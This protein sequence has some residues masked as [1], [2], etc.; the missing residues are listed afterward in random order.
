MAKKVAII[1][2]SQG[3][4]ISHF[5]ENAKTIS[6]RLYRSRAKIVRTWVALPNHYD[7]QVADFTEYYTGFSELGGGS[8]SFDG[9]G[10]YDTIIFISHAGVDDGP[11][12]TFGAR[13]FQPWRR[14]RNDG[15]DDNPYTAGG[16]FKIDMLSSRARR[17]WSGVGASL[18]PDGKIIF[19]GCNLGASPG[20]MRT[21]GEK[22]MSY[23]QHVAN[24]SGRATHAALTANAAADRETAVGQVQAIEEASGAKRQPNAAPPAAL[25]N[26]KRFQPMTR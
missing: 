7:P 2:P 10:T 23:A 4:H 25:T 19:L 16:K 11:N 15:L 17:F 26:M 8:F 14:L 18:K 22:M 3:D 13:G 6:K 5:E 9:E 21:A 20:P 12:L 24:A 1:V